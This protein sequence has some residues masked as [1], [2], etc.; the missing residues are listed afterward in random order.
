MTTSKKPVVGGVRFRTPLLLLLVVMVVTCFARARPADAANQFTAFCYDDLKDGTFKEYVQKRNADSKY[1][2]KFN[3]SA[4]KAECRVGN[5]RITT[6]DLTERCAGEDS[7]YR[8]WFWFKIDK[9]LSGGSSDNSRTTHTKYGH[10]TP[11]YW[12]TDYFYATVSKLDGNP[13]KGELAGYGK[14]LDA[15]QYKKDGDATKLDAYFPLSIYKKNNNL[16]NTLGDRDGGKI[17]LDFYLIDLKEWFEKSDSIAARFEGTI[18]LHTVPTIHNSNGEII[19]H[20]ITTLKDW[21]EK[22]YNFTST[23]RHDFKDHY[24]QKIEI[25]FNFPQVNFEK[26]IVGGKKYNDIYEIGKNEIG[27]K[28]IDNFRDFLQEIKEKIVNNY[29]KNIKFKLKLDIKGDREKNDLVLNCIYNLKPDGG[30]KTTY[31]DFDILVNKTSEGFNFLLE[32]LNSLSD[33]E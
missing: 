15:L 23:S 6:V 18:Y 12:K 33:A 2:A 1:G 31:K 9:H 8:Y 28:E 17:G 3:Y 21:L 26:I 20:N 29:K 10:G 14:D 5:S 19:A 7:P 32:Y 13:L 22:A 24:N 11:L 16:V 27:K 25:K 4:T 30:K